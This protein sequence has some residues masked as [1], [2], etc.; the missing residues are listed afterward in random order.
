MHPFIEFSV[1]SFDAI[2]LDELNRKAEMLDR[3]DR[4]YLVPR[5]RLIMLLEELRTAFDVLE[6]DRQREFTYATTYFD[7]EELSSYYDHHQGRRKRWKVRI[8][9]YKNADFIYLEVKTK[10]CRSMTVKRRLKI[11]ENVVELDQASIDFINDCHRKSYGT[12]LTGA[13]RPVI[14]ME[15]N[16]I[17]LVAKD[18]GE[19]LTIDNDLQFSA[20]QIV[21][22]PD[23]E[24]YIIETKSAR[25]NGLADRVL[26]SLHLQPT[27]H[28]SKYCLGMAATGQTARQN[29]FLPALRRLELQDRVVA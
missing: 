24:K 13:L 7:D 25:G 9:H 5:H 26:R 19:R 20:N 15:Y 22:G 6:I 3:L 16:R 17:T 28:V 12:G 29:T 18:G 23:V 11:A 2:G 1:A 10:E 21:N 27:K 14:A 8:R 4:K